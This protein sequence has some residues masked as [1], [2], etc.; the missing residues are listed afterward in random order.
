MKLER[1]AIGRL[2]EEYILPGVEKMIMADT[3]FS[4]RMALEEFGHPWKEIKPESWLW[5]DLADVPRES[6]VCPWV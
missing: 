3:P 2:L 4:T 6:D 1:P 5:R